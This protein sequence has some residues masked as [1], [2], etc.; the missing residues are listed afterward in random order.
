MHPPTS[1]CFAKHVL[2]LLPYTSISMDARYDILELARFLT[3]LS[4]IDYFFV[5]HRP[6]NVALAALLNAI[7]ASP[8]ASTSAQLELV[9][10]LRRVPGL[11]PNCQ[12]VLECRNRLKVLYSQGGYTRPE[13][14]ARED[15][16]GVGEV[17]AR[18]VRDDTI[19][20]VSVIQ[21]VTNDKFAQRNLENADS[22]AFQFREVTIT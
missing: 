6:S 8:G 10:E 14:L 17:L 2:F 4:V 18:E 22:D 20:P 7:E 13:V 12:E 1:Y 9:S 16:D 19:S 15:R 11:D 21:D 3:E 5:V